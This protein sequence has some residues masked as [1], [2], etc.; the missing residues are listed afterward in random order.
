MVN[1]IFAV[2]ALFLGSQKVILVGVYSNPQIEYSY[3]LRKKLFHFTPS[4]N[5]TQKH[6]KTLFLPRNGLNHKNVY[7]F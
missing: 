3:D 6:S 1:S 2:D 4:E 7:D 5:E